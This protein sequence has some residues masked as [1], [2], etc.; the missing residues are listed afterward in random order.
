MQF[1]TIVLHVTKRSKSEESQNVAK[2]EFGQDVD[3]LVKHKPV[4]A[5]TLLM[6]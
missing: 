4:V 5:Q 3:S 6:M 2:Q 1:Q